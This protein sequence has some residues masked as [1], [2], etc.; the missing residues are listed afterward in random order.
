M[1]VNIVTKIVAILL[2][3]CIGLFVY[4]VTKSEVLLTTTNYVFLDRFLA[5]E[6][7]DLLLGSSTIRRLD[8]DKYLACGTW[9]NRGIGNSTIPDLAHYI[10][11]SSLSIKP[12][13]IILYAGEN[14]LNRGVS[15]E[16][17][18]SSFKQLVKNLMA[19][20][21]NSGIH[22][23]AIKPSPNRRN[24]WGEFN[25]FND[26]LD[27]FSRKLIRVHFH[28]FKKWKK[29]YNLSSFVGDGVHLT[30]EGYFTFTLGFNA[31]C[32]TK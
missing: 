17:T 16:K 24:R 27:S 21:P 4:R 20:Y 25:A 10:N 1:K 30:D 28:S 6:N 32:K 19:R 15:I 29:Q 18:I 23:I 12:S 8:P 22:I 13:N 14:D 7:Y 5:H 2:S 31:T 3:V 26:V 9:L 11:M